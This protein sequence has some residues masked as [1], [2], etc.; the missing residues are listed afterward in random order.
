MNSVG[1]IFKFPAVS[2]AGDI[3]GS[4]DVGTGERG[5]L[6]GKSFAIFGLGDVTAV[7]HDVAVFGNVFTDGSPGGGISLQGLHI[8]NTVVQHQISV[9]AVAD[10]VDGIV[11]DSA[12]VKVFIDLVKYVAFIVKHKDFSSF[13]KAVDDH[14]GVLHGS[15]D[16]HQFVTAPFSNGGGDFSRSFCKNSTLFSVSFN[17]N[18]D[19]AFNTLSGNIFRNVLKKI[20]FLNGLNAFIGSNGF[21]SGSHFR[22]GSSTLSGLLSSRLL[23]PGSLILLRKFRFGSRRFLRRLL[24][25]GLF[26]K[27]LLQ[28]LLLLLKFLVLL[29]L[30]FRLNSGGSGGGIKQDTFFQ[31]HD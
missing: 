23:R 15:A 1:H 12:L 25:G 28:L 2:A 20:R 4:G 19:D 10:N 13:C 16:D 7:K 8:N 5:E 31:T 6:V 26:S 11:L 18:R 29:C 27:L 3:D 9:A 14:F 30:I 17:I 24:S 21:N 22:T